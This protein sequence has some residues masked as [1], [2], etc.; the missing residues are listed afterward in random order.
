M[1]L[2]A[3][4]LDKDGTISR[5]V[6]YLN[7]PDKLEIF[8]YSAAAI[9]MLNNAG[10]RVFVI[11]NQAGIARGLLTENILQAIDKKM[12][13]TLLGQ[14]A[15]IDAVYYCPHH[16][17]HG[18]YPFRKECDCRKPGS[19]MLK[20]AVKSYDIDVAASFMVG[21]KKTDIDAGKDLGV[22]TILIHTGYGKDEEKKFAPG[23]RPDHVADNLFEAVKWILVQ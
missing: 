13:R 18:T 7:D 20:K 9:K 6:G 10:Y 1:S 5:D 23:N 21:D 22:K 3:V 12:I 14:G 17:Q 15:I 4:F 8:P 19:G 2:K 16:P 11:S